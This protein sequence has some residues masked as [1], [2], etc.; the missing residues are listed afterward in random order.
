MSRRCVVLYLTSRGRTDTFHDEDE[1][2]DVE[3]E[4]ETNRDEQTDYVRPSLYQT[5]GSD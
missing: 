1:D 2:D 5:P 3:E 4:N